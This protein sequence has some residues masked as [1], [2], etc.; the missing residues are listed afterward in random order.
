V[1]ISV[2]GPFGVTGDSS[3]LAPRDRVVLEVLALRL[4]E[5]VSPERL[6][7]ALWPESPPPT[8]HKVVQGSVVR[9]RK[10]LGT[11]AIETS[12][13]GYRLTVSPDEVDAHRFERMVH[14]SLELLALGELDRAAYL[15]GE[16]LA[17]W[18]GPPLRELDE[19]DDGRAAAARLDQLRQDAEE[20]H[21]DA[22]LRAGRHREVMGEAQARVAE[23]PLRE[24]RWALLALA[25][26]QAGRQGDALRTLHQARRVL[27]EELGVEPGPDLVTLEQ[28]ILRQDPSLVI[29]AAPP[30]P[31]TTCPY[32][33]LVPYDIRDTDAFYGRD[34]EIEACTRRLTAV[35]VLALIG[36]S[37]SGKSSLV[38]AGV[39]ASLQRT[40]RRVVVITPGVRPTDA[41]TALPAAGPPPVLVVDQ[42]EEVVTLCDDPADRSAFFAAL[43]A[44]AERGPLVIALRADR[45]GELSAHPEFARMIEPGLHVLGAMA[46]EDLR[47]AIEGPARQAGLRLEPGLVD[48]LV[49]EVEGEPGALPLLSHALHQTWQRREGAT[50]TVEG[51]QRTGG[52]R[53][54]IAQS[55]EQVYGD[56]PEDQRALVRDLLLRLVTPTPEGEPVRCRIPRRSLATD[57]AHE[58]VIEQLVAARLVTSDDG[59]IELAHESLARAWPRLRDWL[60][61]DVEGQRILRH[62]AA[63]ADGWESMDRP[64]GELYRGAR[65]AQ[66]LDWQERAAPDLTPAERDFLDVSA[67]REQAE[68]RATEERLRHQARQNRRLRGLLAGVAALLVVALFASVVAARQARRADRAAIVAEQAAATADQ[69][70]VS[71]D[72]RRVGAQALLEQDLD[73]SV[74]L[75]AEGQRL[76]DSPDTRANLLAALS[77]SP[78]LVASARADGKDLISLDVSPD[79]KIVGV[80]EAYGPIAFYRADTRERAGGFGSVPLWKWEFRPDG[81]QLAVTTQTGASG[82]EVAPAQPS[83]RLID[84]ATFDE[85][86]GQ[87]GG[88]PERAWGFQPSYS[89]DGRFLAV[90]FELVDD[91]GQ[92][93]GTSVVIWD[94]ASRAEP[95]RRLDVQGYSTELSPDGRIAYVGSFD[96]PS[97]TAYDVASGR[98]LGSAGV[99]GFVMDLSPDG[100]VLAAAAGNDVVLLE[101]ATMTERHR[102]QGHADL[103]RAL[104][105]SHDGALLASGSDDRTASVW[106]TATGERREVLRGYAFGVWGVGFSED[107]RTLFTTGGQSWLA[108]DLVGDRRFVARHPTKAQTTLQ[109][110]AADSVSSPTGNAVAY[111][112]S[113]TDPDTGEPVALLQ[114]LDVDEGA[115]GAVIDTGHG[116]FGEVAWRP[117]G[118]RLATTGADAHIRVWDWRT[119]QLLLDSAVASGH[120]G[121]LDYTGDGRHLVVEERTGSV[122]SVDAETLEIDSPVADVGERVF[123]VN[124]SPDG[125]TAIALTETGFAIVE[126]ASGRIIH[127]GD[128]GFTLRRGDFSPD[129]RLFAVGGF[130]GEVRL[131]DVESGQWKGPARVSHDGVVTRVAFAPDGATFASGG[132][133]GLIGLWD[134]DTGTLLTTMP[135]GLPTAAAVEFL[136]DGHT[137]LVWTGEG[138]L[139]TWDTRPDSWVKFACTIAGRS[140]TEAEWAEAFG[141]RPY[142]ETC[143]AGPAAPS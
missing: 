132:E 139:A 24:R 117:D 94:L 56:V 124:A 104:R 7:D 59:T 52:I 128:A 143:P 60:D 71:A 27:A 72:A 95:L 99:G 134:A 121:G 61:E 51:Y 100:S 140:L 83:V 42:C 93:T 70:A 30:V 67:E 130:L 26:Y 63:A 105:F 84:P 38:R 1:T 2:L 4:G 103:I 18:R 102:L 10:V 11:A 14:R 34:K 40:G 89:A 123:S 73:R 58:G 33:G 79:G 110:P 8:W 23:A 77:R 109:G 66:A 74:L 107:D 86:A 12:P 118:N 111:F 13:A 112:T 135:N 9:L 90:P 119:G 48:L 39:A 21:V 114:V 122:Y 80:G 129:S 50:L 53:G 64:E 62:L 3:S 92:T 49:R 137:L 54:S 44:H 28:A 116:E 16:A 85:E 91:T 106:D 133:D 41:L 22:A 69:A 141:A 101:T 65:L 19:W 20:V 17:L 6:A 68:T 35:G 138:G 36:P 88:I 87:L 37:G 78:Q 5:V 125:R 25:Q 32:L 120:R 29:D 47:A 142:H 127:R 46:E 55:A 15:S 57:A 76:D 98:V 31:S 81:G 136:P 115:L 82:A 131:L 126:L 45:L 97:V 75:A 108:W 113:T 96:P 43:A